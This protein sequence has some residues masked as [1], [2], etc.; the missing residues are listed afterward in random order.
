MQ[1]LSKIILSS[2]VFVFFGLISYPLY[3]WHWPLLSFAYIFY[4]QEPSVLV[5][6]AM[7]FSSIIFAIITFYF[8]EPKLRYGRYRGFKA[9][10]LFIAMVSICVIS[11]NNLD[12]KKIFSKIDNRNFF[13]RYFGGIGI[14]SSYE[15]QKFIHPSSKESIIVYG[16]SFARQYIP[17]LRNHTNIIGLI[18]DSSLCF[19]KFCLTFNWNRVD[20]S[21]LK[22]D[23]LNKA[24]TQNMADKVLISQRF[25]AYVR[26][27]NNFNKN[28]NLITESIEELAQN[29]PNKEFY[30]LSQPY[31]INP[32]LPEVCFLY[33]NKQINENN[34]FQKLRFK[35]LELCKNKGYSINVSS[36]SDIKRVNSKLTEIADKHV[37][38][39]VIDINKIICKGDYCKLLNDNGFPLHSDHGHLSVWGRDYVGPYILKEMGISN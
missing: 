20:K 11:F 1:K 33:K 4:G 21:T 18:R 5:R 10:A 6:V 37:N 32:S 36:Q 12:N 15:I 30:I 38:L 29:Y 39:K 16:D 8:V 24:L 9:I 3:L 17:Y 23:N 25:I 14:D 2:K 19:S 27:E 13:E 35:N 31:E 34:Y 22:L 7:V 28:L 26:V